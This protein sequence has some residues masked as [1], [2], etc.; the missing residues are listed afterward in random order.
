MTA[1]EKLRKNGIHISTDLLRTIA[2]KYAIQEIDVF[3]SSI[4][5]DMNAES[6]VDLLV[7]FESDAEISLFDIMDLEAELADLFGRTVDVVEAA[8]LTNPVRRH[9]IMSTKELLYAS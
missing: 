8:A 1:R 5:P 6:D 7:T 9:R 2:Q 4:R 3:G